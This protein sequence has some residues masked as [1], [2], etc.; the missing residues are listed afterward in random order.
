MKAYS[1]DLRQ[2]IVEAVKSGKDKHSVAEQFKVSYTSVRNYLKL[3]AGG[4]LEPT[5]KKQT[6]PLKK[7][8]RESIDA[9]KT[10]LEE[11][12]DITLKEIQE[13]LQDE[14]SIRVTHSSIWERL[15]V[16]ELTLKKQSTPLSRIGMTSRFVAGIGRRKSGILQ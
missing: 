16:I 10:W 7:F 15:Q 3:D 14:F 12:N 4:C 11:K 2:R 6:R 5:K 8:T 13:R 9:M 1:L